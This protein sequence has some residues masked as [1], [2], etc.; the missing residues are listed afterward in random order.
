MKIKIYV[1]GGGEKKDAEPLKT[2]C[3]RGF[4][5][6]F[7]KAGL[8]GHMPAIVACGS[9]NQAF[10]KFEIAVQ[11]ARSDEL[12][13]LL[14]DSEGSVI[15]KQGVRSHLMTRDNWNPP[16]SVNDDQIHLMVQC[17][18]NW[19]FADPEMLSRYFGKGFQASALSKRPDVE[20]IPKDDVFSQLE[21]ASRKCQKQ[22]YSKG[23]HSFA[24]L[25]EIDPTKVVNCSP[26]AKRLIDV[27]K[28]QSD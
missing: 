1:E 19:F 27:L 25:A 15:N 24:I 4:R 14:V 3:R 10:R 8:V 28:L 9:R 5:E 6:F 20:N 12:P 23:R 2:A 26:F 11:N 22:T 13:L 18:E 7:E 21:N 17:M 16:L